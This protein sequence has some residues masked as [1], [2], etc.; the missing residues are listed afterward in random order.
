MQ[1]SVRVEL[2]IS[3]HYTRRK[4]LTAF[5]CINALDLQDRQGIQF[6]VVK[7]NRSSV[8][9]DVNIICY[10]LEYEDL[11]FQGLLKNAIGLD[12]SSKILVGNSYCFRKGLIRKAQ[13]AFYVHKFTSKRHDSVLKKG[14]PETF[15]LELADIEY[16]DESM[17]EIFEVEEYLSKNE[18]CSSDDQKTVFVL[19]PSLADKAAEIFMFDSRDQLYEFFERRYCE[20]DEGDLQY[21]R[22]WVVQKYIDRPLLL[23]GNRK[24]HIRAYIVAVGALRVYLYGGMLALFAKKAYDRSN[25]TDKFSHI[26]NTC[27]QSGESDFSE[28][29]SV[30]EFWKLDESGEIS[31]DQLDQIFEGMK[32]VT[33]DVFSALINEASVF[34]PLPNC[35]EIYGLDFLVER[36]TL[37]VYFLE[38]NAFPDFKQTGVELEELIS[39]L[40]IQVVHH[41]V[42][43][44]INRKSNS[45]NS[46]SVFEEKDRRLHLIFDKEMR[47]D[48]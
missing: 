25:L 39:S 10:F 24:F 7:F 15:L 9:E 1:E 21:L 2:G 47:R 8:E 37:Q 19:K 48:T 16:F 26:T 22:E 36:E 29:D 38:A 46:V 5:S 11:D 35:F 33:A 30:K 4:I 13:L 31:R 42:I 20:C 34:Q 18:E 27:I 28:R 23:F 44:L 14:F 40:F 12:N 3:A 6:N 43:P 45:Q 17:N 41:A 32:L